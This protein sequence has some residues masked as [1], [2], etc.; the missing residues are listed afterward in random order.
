MGALAPAASGSCMRR[1]PTPA[2][3]GPSHN[4]AMTDTVLWTAF[5]VLVAL[6]VVAVLARFIAGL[7]RRGAGRRRERR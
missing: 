5:Y 2:H 3:R 1:A 6:V 7:G 4:P